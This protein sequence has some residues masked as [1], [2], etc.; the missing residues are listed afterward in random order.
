MKKYAQFTDEHDI[1]RKAVRDFCLN[2]LATHADDWEAAREFP[3]DVFERMGELGFIGCR[4]PEELGGSGGDIWHTAVLAEELPRA[5][6]AGLTMALLVQSD[7]ATPVIAEL[8]TQEQKEEFLIPALRG[9]KIAALGISEP[10]AGSD[11]AGI[12]TSAQREGDDFI[13][14]GQKT[15]ITNGT[16]ADFITLAVRTDPDNRY[17]GISLF[18]FPTDTPGFSVGQKLEKIGNHCSDT[19][20][21]FFED[22]AL[23]ARY[24]LGEEGAGFYYIM[25]NFQG[26]R[27]V[28]ALTG[29]AS[30]QIVLDETITYCRERHAFDRPLSG[31][32]VTRHKLAEMETQLEACR[33][34]TYHA[35]QLFERGIPCQREI[36]MAKMLAGEHAMKVID[37]CLQ[38]HGGM[39]YVE[40]GPVARAWRDARLLSIAGGTTEI[41]K[42]I[43]SKVMGL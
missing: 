33:A 42:E 37:G 3:R 14:N 29:I 38:L 20:E 41:M 11:V 34:L 31:F 36:S 40:E 24:M 8:G 35:A 5:S 12:R 1:F 19:A 18:L 4:Y 27:L 39:G 30:A 9:E 28:G 2:E 26:E 21:L 32:Q 43:V 17:G 25:Q 7:M 16:R 22:C 13:I 23:P 10:G 15:W 6:M